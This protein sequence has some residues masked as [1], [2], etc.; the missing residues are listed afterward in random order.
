LESRV[1]EESS[2]QPPT[3]LIINALRETAGRI[4]TTV[5]GTC[6]VVI[7]G[8][9]SSG[10]KAYELNE[11]WRTAEEKLKAF[12]SALPYQGKNPEV[13]RYRKIVNNGSVYFQIDFWEIH[14]TI[15]RMRPK[16]NRREL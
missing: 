11:Y 15:V 13:F 5:S 14:S 2:I 10:Q 3:T 7:N 4:I 6:D 12:F 16:A 9:W 8:L 1:I